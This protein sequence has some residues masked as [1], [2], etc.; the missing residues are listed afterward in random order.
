M[1]SDLP[2][3]LQRPFGP[4]TLPGSSPT[5][6][7]CRPGARL[8]FGAPLARQSGAEAP[9]SNPPSW[10]D[11]TT[12]SQTVDTCYQTPFFAA[13]FGC[14]HLIPNFSAG[15]E[16]SPI[17]EVSGSGMERDTFK[18]RRRKITLSRFFS[19][20]PLERRVRNPGR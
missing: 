11:V 15:S 17:K 9:A 6:S 5:T 4:R 8:P 18:S 14:V 2:I 12:L 3:Q 20:S 7:L 1:S 16:I 13:T 10:K 19:L